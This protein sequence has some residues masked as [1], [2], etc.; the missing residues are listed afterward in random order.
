MKYHIHISNKK[1][2]FATDHHEVLF[3]EQ[4]DGKKAIIQE[5]EPASGN[6]YRYLNG[7]LIPYIFYQHPNSQWKDFKDAREAVLWE[8]CPKTYIKALNDERIVQ[9]ESSAGRSKVWLRTLID[10]VVMWMDG[11]GYEVPDNEGYLKWLD[12]CPEVGEVY[13]PMQRLIE[14]YK[15]VHNSL[16]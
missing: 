11:N 8:F 9:R 1:I 14:N 5:D 4:M 3:Y 12:S 16:D 6:L 15:G 7:A 13:P 2:N 10:K